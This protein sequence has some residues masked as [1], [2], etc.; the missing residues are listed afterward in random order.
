MSSNKSAAP[1]YFL[2]GLLCGFFLGASLEKEATVTVGKALFTVVVIVIAVFSRRLE[3]IAHKHHMQ[4]W[5]D[6]RSRGQFYFILTRYVF[7]RGFILVIILV[8]PLLPTLRYS[9]LMLTILLLA[10][11][12]LI[13]M[14]S[15]VGHE[16]WILCEQDYQ[17]MVLKQ[18]AEESRQ[19]TSMTN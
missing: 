6:L 18:A 9:A 12:P 15:Y 5:S 17:V 2:F 13:V 8:G 3:S 4:K 7:L 16:E 1:F 19:R 11:V 14:L 10:F